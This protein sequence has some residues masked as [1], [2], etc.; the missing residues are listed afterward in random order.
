MPGLVWEEA[1]DDSGAAAPGTQFF[2]FPLQRR[3]AA[4]GTQFTCF[5][6]TKVHI[7]TPEERTRRVHARS[8]A[9]KDGLQG[10]I[11]E[12]AGR[13]VGGAAEGGCGQGQGPA[14]GSLKHAVGLL[15]A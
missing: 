1:E 8:V 5:T 2:F 11:L 4:P 3:T 10:A 9:Q 7:L 13:G 12:V 14:A 6:G 15:S